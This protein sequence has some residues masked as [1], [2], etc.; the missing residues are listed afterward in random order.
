MFKNCDKIIRSTVNYAYVPKL[1]K[2]NFLNFIK[3]L[4]NNK[5][6]KENINRWNKINLN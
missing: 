2:E 3:I 5:A 4:E 6:T 1:R